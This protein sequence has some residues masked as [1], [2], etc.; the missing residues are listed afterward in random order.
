MGIYEVIIS[1]VDT[2]NKSKSYRS[3]EIVSLSE[4]EA[5]RLAPYIR[6]L[7]KSGTGPAGPQ[8][9]KGDKG[10]PGPQGPQGPKGDKGD[11]GP[12]GPPG[13]PAGA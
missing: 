1:F 5:R 3:G 10:D 13:P 9:P 11:R 2:K 6:L 8:G 12:V 4:E 7:M